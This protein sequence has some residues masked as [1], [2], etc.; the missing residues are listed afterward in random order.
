[1]LLNLLTSVGCFGLIQPLYQSQVF[2]KS[3][4]FIFKGCVTAHV[5]DSKE[6][7]WK[8]E[9]KDKNIKL[10]KKKKK[11]REREKEKETATVVFHFTD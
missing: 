8:E 5:V 9:K 6:R 2:G 1:M 3:R 11:E 7:G 10:K 4:D